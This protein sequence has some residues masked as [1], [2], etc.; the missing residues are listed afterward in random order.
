MTW[1]YMR[2]SIGFSSRRHQQLNGWLLSLAPFYAGK[3]IHLRAIP[4]PAGRST[5]VWR[6]LTERDF[7]EPTCRDTRSGTAIGPL[8]P[9]VDY[10]ELREPGCLWDGEGSPPPDG[11]SAGAM[12]RAAQRAEQ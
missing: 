8:I 11:W 7:T 4:D 9:L 2:L 12:D 1:K 10:L 5:F 6:S 3:G